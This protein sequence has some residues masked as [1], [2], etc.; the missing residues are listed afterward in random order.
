MGGV[1]DGTPMTDRT[2]D[3]D[4]CNLRGEK[5][6]KNLQ[7]GEFCCHSKPD[8]HQIRAR[9]WHIQSSTSTTN[10]L[11]SMTLTIP[12]SVKNAIGNPASPRM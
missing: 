10:R 11:P 12:L 4:S 6:H 3:R 8:Y 5:N 2:A 1:C 9:V 7:P